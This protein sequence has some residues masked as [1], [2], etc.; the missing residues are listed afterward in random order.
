ME[1]FFKG[2]S[3][4]NNDIDTRAFLKMI[5]SYLYSAKNIG[6]YSIYGDKEVNEEEIKKCIERIKFLC[7]QALSKK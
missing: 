4:K 5:E 1:E 6:L 7:E 2:L 3:F